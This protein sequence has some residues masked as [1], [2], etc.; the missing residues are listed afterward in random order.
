MDDL[1]FQIYHTV[2][3]TYKKMMDD[4]S[5]P[6]LSKNLHARR[7]WMLLIIQVYHRIRCKKIMDDPEFTSIS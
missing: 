5:F 6:S 3:F 1:H 2:E 7:E 4:P